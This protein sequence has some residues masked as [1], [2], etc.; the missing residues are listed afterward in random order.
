MWERIGALLV[1]GMLLPSTSTAADAKAGSP[2][3]TS[4]ED[5]AEAKAHRDRAG[6]EFD[7]GNYQ[8]A[9]EALQKALTLQNTAGAMAMKGSSLNA[10]GRYDEALQTYEK[11]LEQ[12]P[13]ASAG[14]RTKVKGEMEALLAKVG[15]IDVSGDVPEGGRLFVNDRDVGKLPLASPVRVVAGVY[16][17]RAEVAGFPPITAKV[18]VDAGK[19][20]VA[21]L[22]VGKKTGLLEV[23]ELRGWPLRVEL[24]GKDVGVTPW[25]G[26]VDVGEH[27]VRLHGFVD[28]EALQLCEV[29]ETASGDTPDVPEAGARMESASKTVSVGFYKEAR[30]V[31]SAD[32]LDTSLRVDATP[33]GATLRIDGRDV[34]VAPWD[35]RLPL[36]EHA[37]EVR[38]KGYFV[39]KQRVTLERR[40]QRELSIAL[41]R[42]P[43]PPGFW[44]GRTV[45]TTAGL[46]VGLIGLGFFGVAGG[47]ALKNASELRDAC[48]QGICPGGKI[49]QLEETHTLGNVA[50]AGMIVGGVGVV[51][52]A[53]VWVFAAPKEQK[54]ETR[55]QAGIGVRVGVGGVSVEGR[56]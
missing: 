39:S 50:L 14:L 15:T 51:A 53:A 22:A 6:K 2:P 24:D 52:G 37:I 11:V 27:S 54:R 7:R 31:L 40:K 13:N 5:A 4:P 9:Y 29:P 45:G 1:A 23:R 36:G 10:L 48:Q 28:A 26:I 44:T 20:S 19:P 33:A 25:T 55:E 46:G 30:A 32:D 34:G 17:V 16:E 18:S 56:F 38:S 8:E 43:E 47:L 49:E 42:V 3:S 41:E 12:F 35:G 21:K